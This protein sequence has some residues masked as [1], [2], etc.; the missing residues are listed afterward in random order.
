MANREI[1][2]CSWL[3]PVYYGDKGVVFKGDPY[4]GA[5]DYYF[6]CTEHNKKSSKIK[7]LCKDCEDYYAPKIDKPQ[8]RSL[9]EIGT[10]I[11][12]ERGLEYIPPPK[13]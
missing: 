3:I 12:T 8:K 5:R 7:D 11:V 6:E 4:K 10:I 2:R 13:P 9:R 1:E